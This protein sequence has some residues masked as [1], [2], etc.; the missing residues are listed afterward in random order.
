MNSIPLSFASVLLVLPMCAQVVVI[1]NFSV[2]DFMDTGAQN[3][4]IVTQT[5]LN[6]ADVIGGARSRRMEHAGTGYVWDVADN[7]MRVEVTFGVSIVSLAW[8]DL[9]VS[10]SVPHEYVGTALGFDLVGSS[11]QAFQL[12]V[13]TLTGGSIQGEIVVQTSALGESVTSPFTLNGPGTYTIPFSSLAG[14][15]DL[16]EINGIF[17]NFP[18]VTLPFGSSVN[19]E[20]SS[21]T[22][23]PEPAE[24][25]VAVGSLMLGWGVWRRR[26]RN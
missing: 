23:V 22:M 8:G 24:W 10:D 11:N 21:F 25:A 12:V 13:P 17:L 5:G 18:N 3:G 1:D 19:L 2:G 4:Q 15:A 6:P 14:S 9:D 16:G 7:R 20:I 26:V